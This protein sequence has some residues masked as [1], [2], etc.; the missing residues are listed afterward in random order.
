MKI[1]ATIEKI[2]EEVK[3]RDQR[4]ANLEVL[5]LVGKMFPQRK[6]YQYYPLDPARNKVNHP[7][8]AIQDINKVKQSSISNVADLPLSCPRKHYDRRIFFLTVCLYAA[9]GVVFQPLDS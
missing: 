3:P 1:N 7:T 5:H 2:V 6:C 8:Y 9:N 4:F